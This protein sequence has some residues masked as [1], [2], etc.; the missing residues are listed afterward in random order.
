MS[1][2]IIFLLVYHRHKLLDLIQK[3]YSLQLYQSKILL[4]LSQIL[5]CEMYV[6]I[7]QAIRNCDFTYIRRKFHSLMEHN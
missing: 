3:H 6:K 4:S 1:K 2:N 7:H 5:I